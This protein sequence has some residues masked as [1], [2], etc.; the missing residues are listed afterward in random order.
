VNGVVVTFRVEVPDPP[1]V[2]G[3]DVGLSVVVMVGV[4][5]TTTEDKETVPENPL[6]FR[7]IWEV[8]KLPVG[9]LMVE[10]LALI[11]KSGAITNIPS[12]VVGWIMQ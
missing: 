10:G 12:I 2:R 8:P 7:V 9:M 3:T 5:G 6:L 4:L 1:G 11:E